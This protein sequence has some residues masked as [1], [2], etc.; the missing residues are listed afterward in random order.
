MTAAYQAEL[1]V[2]PITM[3]MEQSG[4]RVDVPGLRRLSA[5]LSRMLVQIDRCICS[6]LGKTID[7]GSGTQLGKALADADLLS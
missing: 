4:I 1:A 2:L 5:A 7:V 6:R 3:A